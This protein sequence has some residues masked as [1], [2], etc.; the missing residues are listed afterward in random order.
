MAGNK[1]KAGVDRRR[2]PET[3]AKIL[4]SAEMLFSWRGFYGVSLRDIAADAGVPVALSHYHF[5]SKEAL[6]SA[7]IER[8]AGEH[9]GRIAEALEQARAVQ[10]NRRMRREAIIR[11]FMSPIA[12]RSM[13]GGPGWKNYIRL[14]AF[15]ANHP[16]EEDYVAPF[17]THYDHLIHA[18]IS[19]L[20]ALHPEMEALD[21][22]WGFFFYQAATTHILVESG[23]LDRQ[24]EGQLKSSDLDAM[25]DRMVPFFSAGFLGLG[26]R[27]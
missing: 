25:L 11:A 5:G 17:K 3:A 15:V 6:F 21:V 13:R 1:A 9:A 22:E 27:D 2:A 10:G 23:L 16:Q 8:R 19:A 7:V 26:A 20:A 24:T 18:F 4:D 14:L 12:E